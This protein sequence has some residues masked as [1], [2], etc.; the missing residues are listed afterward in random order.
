MAVLSADVPDAVATAA[1]PPSMA[2]I[3]CSNTS[4]VGLFS[5]V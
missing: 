5:R 1:S 2:A 4:T 3:R